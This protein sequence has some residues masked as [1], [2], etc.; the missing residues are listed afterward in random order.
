MNLVFLKKIFIRDDQSAYDALKQ[1]KINGGKIIKG[2]G[3]EKQI[4]RI[5]GSKVGDIDTALNVL[6]NRIREKINKVENKI[7]SV[8]QKLTPDSQKQEAVRQ[9]VEKIV[10]GEELKSESEIVDSLSKTAGIE[11]NTATTEIAIKGV[12]EE[13]QKAEEE[14]PEAFGQYRIKKF[15]DSCLKQA[16]LENKELNPEQVQDLEEMVNLRARVMNPSGSI[17]NQRVKVGEVFRNQS[18]GEV[19]NSWHNLKAT[20]GLMRFHIKPSEVLNKDDAIETKLR[21]GGIRIPSNHQMDA[22]DRSK[23]LLRRNNAYLRRLDSIQGGGNFFVRLRK[24]FYNFVG[25][26]ESS[27]GLFQTEGGFLSG[28]GLQSASSFVPN[29]VG[30]L[31]QNGFDSGL[32]GVLKGVVGSG[33]KSAVGNLA[34]DAALKLA[35][36]ALGPAGVAAAKA[37]G[38]LKKLFG[39]LGSKLGPGIKNSL[40]SAFDKTGSGLGK[41]AMGLGALL[42]SVGF[43]GTAAASTVVGGA[44]VGGVVGSVAYQQYIVPQEMISG[45]VAVEEGTVLVKE[46]TGYEV[47]MEYVNNTEEI[48]E[49]ELDMTIYNNELKRKIENSGYQTRYAVAAAAQY[50]AIDFPYHVPYFFGG[51]YYGDGL[52][53]DWGKP[54]E[55]DMGNG[56]IS[57]KPWG[58]DCNSFIVWAFRQGGFAMVKNGRRNTWLGVGE[59][60]ET[61]QIAFNKEN[62]ERIKKIVKPGDI[63]NK[64]ALHKGIVI[65]FD[66]EKLQIAQLGGSAKG[67]N[68]CYLNP[69]T[70]SGQGLTNGCGLFNDLWSMDNFFEYYTSGGEDINGFS[71]EP[72]SEIRSLKN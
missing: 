4:W 1:L 7:I 47:N 9:E 24:T 51:Y 21:L 45:M 34:G 17:E 68:V 26:G 40:G 27:G 25:G 10:I 57:T 67:L 41:A 23:S 38:V 54:E 58:M 65:G 55:E 29:S 28:V 31:M 16:N 20:V 53:E 70:G 2:S 69:C 12:L 5:I 19:Q 13:L 36:G 33:V 61:E 30:L 44:V 18:P 59:G 6:N 43:I 48:P 32:G 46:K 60:F 11:E 64:S 14:N 42:A 52:S 3:I 56:V 15:E 39:G 63:V 22:F 71:I 72:N 66:G 8:S 50:L 49:T 35:G 62:C 37:L